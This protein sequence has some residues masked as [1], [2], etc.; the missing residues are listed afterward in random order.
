MARALIIQDLHLY[1]EILEQEL[2]RVN[3][4]RY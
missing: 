4:P 1:L 2:I 3:Y